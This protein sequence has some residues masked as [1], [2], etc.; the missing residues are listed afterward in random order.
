VSH[1]LNT[2]APHFHRR[3]ATSNLPCHHQHLL[4]S[5]RD[6][7]EFTV[8]P[9]NKNVGPCILKYEAY[10]KRV[11][12]DHLLDASTYEQLD[13]DAA[14]DAV[15]A[16]LHHIEL[17]LSDFGASLS[18]DDLIYISRSLETEDPF[19]YFYITAKTST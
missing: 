9:S 5:L 16:T 17:F 12:Q 8:F 13:E 7:K 11:F 4:Q 14:K 1:F 15:N 10:I 3:H 6:N 19:A 18:K 2:L